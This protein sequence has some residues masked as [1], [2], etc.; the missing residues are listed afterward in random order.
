[1]KESKERKERAMITEEINKRDKKAIRE[2]GGK[3]MKI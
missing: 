3:E 1:V 2:K